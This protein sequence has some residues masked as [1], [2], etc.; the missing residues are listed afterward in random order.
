MK[1]CSPVLACTVSMLNLA[2]VNFLLSILLSATR[3]N[4]GFLYRLE[5]DHVSHQ[6]EYQQIQFLFHTAWLC[7]FC[8]GRYLS[9]AKDRKLK[10]GG[11]EKLLEEF[12]ISR[13]GFAYK[14]SSCGEGGI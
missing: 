4:F 13:C 10:K 7:C 11:E 14:R 9:A 1:D 8:L 6:R 2:C 3:K 12:I 5:I